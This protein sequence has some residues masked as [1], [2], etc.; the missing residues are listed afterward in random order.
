MSKIYRVKPGC[1]KW[2]PF[3][4]P[5]TYLIEHLE[6]ELNHSIEF[7]YRRQ[8]NKIKLTKI[9]CQYYWTQYW[10]QILNVQLLNIQYLNSWLVNLLLEINCHTVRHIF[11]NKH[12][13]MFIRNWVLLGDKMPTESQRNG[14]IWIFWKNW[15]RVPNRG[16]SLEGGVYHNAS[17]TVPVVPIPSSQNVLKE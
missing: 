2:T 6:I 5:G 4:S 11:L 12:P 7:D 16:C 15:T 8:S 1:I 3:I 13:G 10:I 17:V 9:F 14:C